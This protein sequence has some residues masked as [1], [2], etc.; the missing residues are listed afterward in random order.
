MPFSDVLTDLHYK[1]LKKFGATSVAMSKKDKD[2]CNEDICANEVLPNKESVCGNAP[3]AKDCKA[4]IQCKDMCSCW[5]TA[6][7][8][9]LKTYEVQGGDYGDDILEESSSEELA[10]ENVEEETS[11][12]IQNAVSILSLLY[13]NK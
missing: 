3:M 11:L 13:L 7:C 2:L 8:G 10:E 9:A 12:D 1:D 6:N 4:T 5:V